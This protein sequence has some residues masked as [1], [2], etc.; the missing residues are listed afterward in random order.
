MVTPFVDP[1]CV[2]I[3]NQYSIRVKERDALRQ[4]L[5][6]AGIGTEIY[7]PVPM[8]KQECFQGRCRVVGSLE[9]SEAVANEVLALPIY[10]ELTEEQIDFVART[11]KQGVGSRD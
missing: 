9:H 5:K 2:S 6:E 8:H 11:V 10:P 1:D 4:A 3:Y 7:Y